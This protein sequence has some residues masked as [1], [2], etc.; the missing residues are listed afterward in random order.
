ML[1]VCAAGVAGLWRR[2][3]RTAAWVAV[4]VVGVTLGTLL[5]ARAHSARACDRL[6]HLEDECASGTCDEVEAYRDEFLA[7]VCR[8]SL[9][10]RPSKHGSFQFTRAHVRHELACEL[11]L[12]ELCNDGET[13]CVNGRQRTCE[14]GRWGKGVTCSTGACS[15]AMP[16]HCELVF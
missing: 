9:L 14:D 2:R 16:G 6:K 7:S 11:P 3:A 1:S 13:S 5:A 8:S 12:E 15:T 10:C 4:V